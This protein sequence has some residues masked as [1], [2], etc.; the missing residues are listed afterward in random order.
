MPFRKKGELAP[1]PPHTPKPALGGTFSARAEG[2]LPG[3]GY[4][5]EFGWGQG[6]WG[7][8]PAEGSRDTK[9]LYPGAVYRLQSPE[10]LL[11][12]LRST[13]LRDPLISRFCESRV[14]RVP[15]SPSPAL[16]A[17]CLSDSVGLDS[18]DGYVN[19]TNLATLLLSSPLL[20]TIQR[21]PFYG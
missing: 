12:K 18:T 16:C 19:R 14:S 9:R 4:S 6:E 5:G 15:L 7:V 13:S 20:A 3:F 11:Q 17:R 8:R 2:F 1:T 10:K 21:R